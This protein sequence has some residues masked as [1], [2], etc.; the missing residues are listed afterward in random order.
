MVVKEGVLTKWT[1][2]VN[3]WQER[4]I[5]LKGGFLSYF[6]NKQDT[7]SLCRGM[8]RGAGN[9]YALVVEKCPRRRIFLE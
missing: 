4:Y 3:G 1:N 9:R 7:K 2:Y 5:V 8:L 6:K